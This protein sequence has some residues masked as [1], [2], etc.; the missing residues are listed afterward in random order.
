MQ[1][2]VRKWKKEKFAFSLPTLGL[3]V[4]TQYTNAWEA[5][6]RMASEKYVRPYWFRAW[7]Y[8]KLNINMPSLHVVKQNVVAT[9][10]VAAVQ[11]HHDVKGMKT[12][13]HVL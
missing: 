10:Y 7:S 11:K 2:N 13:V 3:P 1:A 4:Y 12:N 5:T 9:R 6:N 8:T